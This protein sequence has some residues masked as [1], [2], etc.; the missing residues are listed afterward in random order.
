MNYISTKQEENTRNEAA[1][2]RQRISLCIQYTLNVY[3]NNQWLL[4]SY[5]LLLSPS[6][7]VQANTTGIHFQQL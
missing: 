5:L 1:V 4:L 7:F 2:T 3:S 6:Q